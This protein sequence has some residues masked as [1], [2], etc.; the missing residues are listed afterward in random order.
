LA[1]V[2]AFHRLTRPLPTDL[3]GWASQAR[4][5]ADQVYALALQPFIGSGVQAPALWQPLADLTGLAASRWQ[6]TLN[7]AADDYRQWLIPG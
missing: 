7:V 4:S 5:Y 3:S 1:M 2:G 6:T